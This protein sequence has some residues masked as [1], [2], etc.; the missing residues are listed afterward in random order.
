[1][2]CAVFL[3]RYLC[4]CSPRCES[5][6]VGRWNNEVDYESVGNVMRMNGSMTTAERK[7]NRGREE[8]SGHWMTF[9]VWGRGKKKCVRGWQRNETEKK[10]NTYVKASENSS[11]MFACF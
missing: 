7:E 10:E 2:M 8:R 6:C 1:M 9:E 4:V 11:F 5:A 3:H